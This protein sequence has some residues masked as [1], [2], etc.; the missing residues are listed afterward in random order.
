M[1]LGQ[2]QPRGC[3]A[4]KRAKIYELSV[5]CAP[6]SAEICT[7]FLNVIKTLFRGMLSK[8]E[9]TVELFSPD[10]DM[11]DAEMEK[12]LVDTLPN[13]PRIAS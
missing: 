5:F 8:Y 2:A 9:A 1:H 11:R 13:M 12:R 6:A 3:P 7:S 4:W 10:A